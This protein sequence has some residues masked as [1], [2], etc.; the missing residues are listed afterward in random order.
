MLHKQ[1]D[2]NRMPVSDD[3]PAL[4]LDDS[5][6][7]SDY[8]LREGALNVWVTVGALSVYIMRTDE[9]VAIDV[10]PK[11]REAEDDALASC[12]AFNADAEPSEDDTPTI[13]PG[14]RARF[15]YPEA[16][17]TLPDYS[18][19]RGQTVRVLRQLTDDECDPECQPMFEIEAQDGW[20]GRADASELEPLND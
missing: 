14:T 17:V 7:G 5:Q 1:L 9:G 15:N 10:Y 19:H 11:G 16:F 20:K 4:T 12:Y 6:G 18:A 3:T 8:T 2:E 13:Q